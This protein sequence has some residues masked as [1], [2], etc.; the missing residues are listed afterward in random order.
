MKNNI[1]NPI[2]MVIDNH[3]KAKANKESYLSEGIPA[4][5]EMLDEYKTLSDNLSKT[6][7]HEAYVKVNQLAEVLN[8]FITGSLPCDYELVKTYYSYIRRSDISV[9]MWKIQSNLMVAFKK[10]A[11]KDEWW[12]YNKENFIAEYQ[13]DEEIMKY[14]NMFVTNMESFKNKWTEMCKQYISETLVTL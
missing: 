1:T 7:Y 5:K 13:N 4:V 12:I 14:Y 3:L 9:D 10:L 8:A 11:E 2:E 6:N